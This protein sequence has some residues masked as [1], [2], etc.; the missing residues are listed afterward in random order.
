MKTI[1]ATGRATLAAA[2][3]AV[4]VAGCRKSD[5]PA[6]E[7]EPK[8][9][10]SPISATE[11]ERGRQACDSYA[12]QVCDCALAQPDL[13]GECDLARSRPGAFELNLRSAMAEGNASLRDRSAI[14]AN[15]RKIARACIE[16]AAALIKR[17]CPVSE[18]VETRATPA[19]AGM[20][21]RPAAPAPGPDRS[22]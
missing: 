2:F 9:L 11:A 14:Q 1:G 5:E 4:A 19:P 15:A 21:A 20:T 7:T 8:A 10:P 12:D 18:P 17:G 16:D 3:I 22:R 6:R 13:T